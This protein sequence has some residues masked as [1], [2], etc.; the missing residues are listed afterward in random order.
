MR[1]FDI[2][3]N[4]NR[5]CVA[6]INGEGVLTAILDSVKTKGRDEMGITVG[7]LDD[8]TGEHLTWIGTPL[9]IDDEVRIKVL[10]AANADAPLKR[11]RTDPA[12]DTEAKKNYVREMAKEFGWTLTE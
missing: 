6:G 8:V 10:D 5:L 12:R 1:V 3:V 4:G 11:E 2:Y 7:G 9:A